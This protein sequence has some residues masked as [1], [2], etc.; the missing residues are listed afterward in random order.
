MKKDGYHTQGKVLNQFN[1]TGFKG[2]GNHHDL[3]FDLLT[4]KS[5]LC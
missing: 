2:F 3:N 5:I 4:F 1:G